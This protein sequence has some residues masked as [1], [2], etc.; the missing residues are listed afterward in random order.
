M[1]I[2]RTYFSKDTTIVRN[3]CVNTGRNP[4]VELFYAG[5][6]N[7]NNTKYSRYLFD[8]DLTGLT[9]NLSCVNLSGGSVTHKIKMTNTLIL[10]G[11]LVGG[12]WSLSV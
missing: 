9:Q 11:F 3:S 4:I 10:L 5:S 6:T 8:I 1:G 2:L 7:V 12:P